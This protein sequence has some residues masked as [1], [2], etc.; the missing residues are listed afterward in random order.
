M[1]KPNPAREAAIKV[2]VHA[3]RREAVLYLVQS[4]PDKTAAE[5]AELFIPACI[6]DS[7]DEPLWRGVDPATML[8]ILRSLENKS[9]VY[10]CEPKRDSRAGRD[11]PTWRAHNGLE[12]AS[13]MPPFCDDS[14]DGGARAVVPR[15]T[16]HESD[17]RL[18]EETPRPQLYTLLEV[19]S[20]QAVL[21]ARLLEDLE[22]ERRDRRDADDR[23]DR[24][25]RDMRDF[26][27]R[28]RAKLAGAGFE[29]PA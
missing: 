25:L 8:G 3:W 12:Q 19:L 15:E 29:V 11:V 7:V 17:R 2:A 6:A 5:L 21:N 27:D 23:L 20:E 4:N 26:A 1:R 22:R 13:R 14:K 10:R 18:W 24:Y 9:L 16:T 28:A